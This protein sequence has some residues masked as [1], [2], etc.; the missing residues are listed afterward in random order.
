MKKLLYIH[1]LK[2]SPDGKVANDAKRQ[3]GQN[4]EE[5]DRSTL[6]LSNVKKGASAVN[7]KELFTN[8]GYET[9]KG[10]FDLFD[11]RGTLDEIK[12]LVLK[13]KVSLVVA[14]SLGAFYALAFESPVPVIALNPAFKPTSDVPHLCDVPDKTIAAWQGLEQKMPALK[15]VYKRAKFAVFAQ[16][17]E[18]FHHKDD[19]DSVF[20]PGNSVLVEGPHQLSHY[21]TYLDPGI[22]LI[23]ARMK[24]AKVL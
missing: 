21:R 24:A 9:L 1:G 8:Y 2:V 13:N 12:G 3:M 18:L 14:S 11:V 7:I 6:D 5:F 4:A 23:V 16:S 19:F 15:P 10:T 20:T 22:E 17:D